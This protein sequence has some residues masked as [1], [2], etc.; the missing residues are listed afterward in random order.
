MIGN[1]G[2][3]G[4]SEPWLIGDRGSDWGEGV[5]AYWDRVSWLIGNRGCDWGEGVLAD[6][7]EGVLADWEPRERELYLPQHC[8]NK[9]QY[10]RGY[11]WGRGSWL[12]GTGVLVNWEQGV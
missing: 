8:K 3:I 12:I 10:N 1:R 4:E 2:L 6:W 9:Q 7:G 11:D 5:V